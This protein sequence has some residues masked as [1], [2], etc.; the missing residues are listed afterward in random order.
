MNHYID[1]SVFLEVAR[2]GG[3]YSPPKS[4]TVTSYSFT[5]PFSSITYRF[6]ATLASKKLVDRDVVNVFKFDEYFNL[7]Q[8]QV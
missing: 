7:T 5:M 3:G 6:V 2:R 4:A 8:T 1:S